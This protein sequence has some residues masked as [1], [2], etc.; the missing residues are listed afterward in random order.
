MLLA[1]LAVLRRHAVAIVRVRHRLF[2]WLIR[3]RTSRACFWFAQK[4]IVFSFGSIWAR[5]QLHPLQ[6]ALADLDR[7]VEVLLLETSCPT[8]TSPSITWSSD[9]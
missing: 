5:E 4:T 3:S 9:V 8:S 2:T 6:L 7:D 1:Q